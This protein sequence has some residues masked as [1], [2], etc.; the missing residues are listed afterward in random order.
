MIYPSTAYWLCCTDRGFPFV[1]R[2]PIDF[3]FHAL[4]RIGSIKFLAY[5]RRIE[6]TSI[7]QC[8]LVSLCFFFYSVFRSYINAFDQSPSPLSPAQP[9]MAK[10]IH[11]ICTTRR[12]TR[13]ALIDKRREMQKYTRS[14]AKY[15]SPTTTCGPMF[16][17]KQLRRTHFN[18]RS[19]GI[20]SF[21]FT[22]IR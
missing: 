12:R 18:H 19:G 14:R 22:I 2:I 3:I 17:K 9:Y 16:E 10:S 20:K 13:S 4:F 7:S 1:E 11:V 21:L 15:M 5:F 8:W 6:S